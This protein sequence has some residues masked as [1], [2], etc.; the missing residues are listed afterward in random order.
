MSCFTSLWRGPEVGLP[1]SRCP[2]KPGLPDLGGKNDHACNPLVFP[3]T[4]LFFVEL[5]FS[6]KRHPEIERKRLF[7]I[8]SS[9]LNFRYDSCLS[10]LSSKNTPPGSS[11]RV[12]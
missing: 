5:P 1:V 6:S 7:A 3:S 12:L 9:S 4:L 2:E 8:T 11:L 10:I